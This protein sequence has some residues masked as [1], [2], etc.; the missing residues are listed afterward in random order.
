V[1]TGDI[2]IDD[3]GSCVV[4]AVWSLYGHAL[5]RLGQVP[6]LIEWD[7]DVPPLSVLL[8]EATRARQVSTRAHTNTPTP[9]D[10]L[11]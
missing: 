8:D 6:T 3:H 4:D 2:V 7:T 9:L 1:H 5:H 10:A 11:A